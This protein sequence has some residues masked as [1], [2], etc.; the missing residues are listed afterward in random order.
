MSALEKFVD[1]QKSAYAVA[2]QEI[3]NGRK[4][5]HWMWYIFPQ[6][7]GLGRSYNAQFYAI[8]SLAEAK[9][10]LEHPVLGARIREISKALLEHSGK[11]VR[12]ILGGI[13]SMKLKSSM[14]LFDAVSADD[15]FADVL[16]VFFNGKRDEL[17]LIKLR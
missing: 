3:K 13:D 6:I 7:A 9:E 12:E 14:T 5:S 15:V 8:S 1:A 17:T 10:Y 4:V 16:R 2:L 11:D